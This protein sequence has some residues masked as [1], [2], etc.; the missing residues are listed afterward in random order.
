M[1]ES[2]EWQGM[3]TH[4]DIWLLLDKG[5]PLEPIVNDVPAYDLVA[6]TT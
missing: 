5:K 6:S 3:T 4:S 2:E 1:I